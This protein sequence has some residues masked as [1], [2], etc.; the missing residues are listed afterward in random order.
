MTLRLV[1]AD[2]HEVVRQ[3]CRALL[4]R[5]GFQVVGEAADGFEAVRLVR[6]VQPDVAVLDLIMPGMNGLE[7]AEVIFKT[8]PNTAVVMLSMRVDEWQVLAA[9]KSGIRAYVAKS[10][11]SRDLVQAIRTV[12]RGGLF[13]SRR[14]W[15]GLIDMFLLSGEAPPDPLQGE[16]RMLLRLIAEGKTNVEIAEALHVGIKTAERHR[17]ALM[18]K[19]DIHDVPGLVRFAVRRGLIQPIVACWFV[20]DQ[21]LAR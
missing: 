10:E 5:E 1:L 6:S 13:L 11:T 18:K 21:I 12:A 19:L 20:V 15:S 7:A 16:E 3:G 2:D 9:L 14:V 4:E 17:V 8:S